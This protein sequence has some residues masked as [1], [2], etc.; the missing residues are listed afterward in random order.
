MQELIHTYS[1]PVVIAYM[2]HSACLSVL[3]SLLFG[4]LIVAASIVSDIFIVLVC[5]FSDVWGYEKINFF[6]ILCSSEERS[7]SRTRHADG[8]CEAI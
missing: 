3:V 5:A 2:H 4:L 7:G 1:L 8:S 6:C